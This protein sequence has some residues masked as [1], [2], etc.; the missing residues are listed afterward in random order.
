MSRP[1]LLLADNHLTTL[2]CWRALLAAEF[3]VVGTVEDGRALVGAYDVLKP[4]AI[5]SDIGV[6][7]M[8]GVEAAAQILAN[9]A[10]AR[11]VF[12]TVHADRTI[13]RQALASGALGYVLK[14]RVGEDL[15]PAIRSALR[16]D[17]FISPFPPLEAGRGQTSPREDRPAGKDCIKLE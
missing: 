6:P 17:L 9:H 10:D 11:I 1:R 4:D 5:V 2:R 8:N 12:A 14:V 15:V 7:E 3:D 16:G 13:L